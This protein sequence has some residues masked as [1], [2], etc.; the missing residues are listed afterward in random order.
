MNSIVE[1]RAAI[2]TWNNFCSIKS[3]KSLHKLYSTIFLY[4][5]L[6]RAKMLRILSGLT[7]L[8]CCSPDAFCR[9]FICLLLLRCGDVQPNPGPGTL[10][11]ENGLLSVC[12][13]NTNSLY[14]RTDQNPT[15]KIDEIYSTFCI[16]NKCHVICISETWLNGTI[17]DC[18]I[19]LPGYN[20]FRRDRYDGYGG[21]AI[22]VSKTIFSSEIVDMRS[23]VSEN[24]WVLIHIG[25]KKIALAVF[26]RPPNADPTQ[27]NNFIED[28]QD[29]LNKIYE[30]KPHHLLITGDFNDRRYTWSMNHANSDLKN[31]FFDLLLAN[32][33]TQLVNEP[34]HISNNSTPSILD[35]FITDT[36]GIIRTVSVETPIGLCHHSPILCVLKVPVNEVKSYKR[37]IWLYDKANYN[38]LNDY[39]LDLPW[40]MILEPSVQINDNLENFQNVFSDICTHFI[41]NKVVHIRPRDKPWMTGSIRRLL[42][43]RNRY[44]K[45]YKKKHQEDR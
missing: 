41:P 23:H 25:S 1:Y 26:Y 18:N 13:I 7:L 31:A 27:V 22:Y 9:I 21:V 8:H 19:E 6:N 30:H 24:I 33:L 14:V 11:I 39:L 45:M 34:T 32:N 28:F 4:C 37:H 15:Y 5:C 44:H 12:H 36:P 10:H 17:P 16:D 29:Q 38:D 43:K 20:L 42:R 40:N 3:M 2:G 35:L